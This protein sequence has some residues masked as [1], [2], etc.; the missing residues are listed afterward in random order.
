M[1][2]NNGDP[3]DDVTF[4]NG[5]IQKSSKQKDIYQAAITCI[6]RKFSLILILIINI[7]L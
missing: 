5:T 3:N 1:G 2:N 4:R 6:N 7:Y